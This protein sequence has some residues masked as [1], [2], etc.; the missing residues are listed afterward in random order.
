MPKS[1]S[2]SLRRFLT[3]TSALILISAASTASAA[4]LFKNQ[5]ATRAND[6]AHISSSRNVSIDRRAMQQSSLTFELDGIPVNAVRDRIERHKA[7]PAVWI[8]HLAG[9]PG[10]TVIITS[11]RSTFSGVI[12]HKGSVF[13]LS[14]NGRGAQ[15]L[16]KIDTSRLPRED[17][18]GIPDGGGLVGGKPLQ[19]MHRNGRQDLSQDTLQDTSQ[20]LSDLTQQDLLVVYT[21][22][23]CTAAGGSGDTECN[24]IQ[25][26]ITTAVAQL[27]TA[28]I[29]SGIDI[30]MNVTSMRFINYADA[31]VSTGTALGQI[32]STSDGIMDEVHGWRDDDG[33]DM[34]ALIMDGT[35]CGTAYAPASPTS[36]F[37][38][39][40]ESC[41]VG[42]RTM[43]HEI[44][45]NQGAL[46]DRDQ[47]GGGTVGAYNYGFKR[48]S[49]GSDEDFGAPYFRTVMSYSCSG[50]SRVGRFS[51]P[52]VLFSG[53]P[54]GIDPAITPARGAWNARTL[55]ESAAYVAGF[56]TPVVTTPPAAPSGL[57]AAATGNNAI[58]LNWTDNADNESSFELE[59]STDGSNWSIIASLAANSTSFGDSGLTA[60][61]E[62]FYRVQTANSAGSSVFS[63]VANATTTNVSNTTII[64]LSLSSST[65]QGSV[66][67][68][69]TATHADDGSVQ[70]ITETSSRGPKRSPRQSY[71]HT[72]TFDVTGGAGGVVLT[73]NAWVSGSES[74]IFE[75]STD[76]ANS[77][78]PMFTISSNA[79]STTDSFVL[80]GG[81]SGA[82]LV[83]ARD[84]VLTNGE[85]VDSLSVD[86]LIITS[87]T[88]AGSPPPSPSTMAITGQ[89]AYTVSLSFMDNSTNEFGFDIWRNGSAPSS[90]SDGIVTGT[91]DA[92]SGTGTVNFTDLRASPSTTYWYFAKSFNGAGDDGTCSNSVSASTDPEPTMTA[93]G[94]GYKISGVHT[95]DISWMGV[96]TDSVDIKRDGTTIATTANDVAYTDNIGAKGGAT[97][98]Y[99]VCEAGTFTC[100]PTFN[101]VF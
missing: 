37:N 6:A 14:G 79:N 83:R 36:A 81:T 35:G 60:N 75:Y 4:P 43:A 12:H 10:D 54:Q 23:A 85:S 86:S 55:N 57:G 44:G 15:Y 72:W 66:S 20:V 2:I 52:N 93:S 46:H 45:H 41:M 32:R 30:L 21:Q 59:R 5:G 94:T 73:T 22:G 49:D 88:S 82:L 67:G 29:E 56:R 97:Y 27:N 62:Y 42:N 24:Q 100:A 90:C 53:V 99:E 1:L 33:A 69:H 8:G 34:V 96:T 16:N 26:D 91:A 65:S 17:L 61:T 95:V 78:N 64:D 40:D 63:N 47:H 68:S 80:P 9:S 74:A 51:N 18:G 70:T 19:D 76:N 77:W 50:A 98:T 7:G 58:D 101:I 13:E 87:N 25:A 28:Y 84:A 31:G 92:S 11:H 48:C 3:G 71:T 89:S 39:T 38:V